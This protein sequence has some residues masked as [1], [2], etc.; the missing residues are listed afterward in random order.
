MDCFALLIL[1]LIFIRL[2]VSARTE[3][4]KR[5]MTDRR[6]RLRTGTYRFGLIAEIINQGHELI[7]AVVLALFA[8]ALV[9]G[10]PH[11]PNL[12]RVTKTAHAANMVV[13]RMRVHQVREALLFVALRQ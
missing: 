9:T 2:D 3:H 12:E 4:M 8:V 11:L 7:V 5:H 6:P 1:G 10:V 13:V